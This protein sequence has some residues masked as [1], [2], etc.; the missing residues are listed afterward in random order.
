MRI[1]KGNII[2]NVGKLEAILPK[3][4]QVPGESFRVS[5]SVRASVPIACSYNSPCPMRPPCKAASL[6]PG[7][8]FELGL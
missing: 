6:D 3:S 1:D 2:V 8:N 4:E 5:A 7:G